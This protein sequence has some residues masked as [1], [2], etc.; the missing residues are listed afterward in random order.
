MP[1]LSYGAYVF[2]DLER[3][4]VEE[5]E[6]AYIIWQ[7]LAN[8]ES[9]FRLFNN[10]LSSMRRYELLRYLFEE[11]VNQFNVQRLTEPLKLNKFPIFIRS[12]DDHEAS[13][14]P[15][16]FNTKQYNDAV[17]TILK[18]GK[19]RDNKI[20]IEY[21]DTRD[22][23]GFFHRFS[24]IVAGFQ[25]IAIIPAHSRD[26]IVKEL[27]YDSR[28]TNANLSRYKNHIPELIRIFRAANINY[29]RADY[30][31]LDNKIQIFEINTNP[32]IGPVEYLAKVAQILDFHSEP[33]HVEIIQKYSPPWKERKSKSYWAGR[34]LH[35]ILRTIDK[36]EYE[37]S[38]LD[39]LK[40]IKK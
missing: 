21:I 31:V 17:Q 9:R 30:V 19:S 12:E 27:P 2:A 37:G 28:D 39:T 22:E 23:S 10:P 35:H 18:N 38:I 16:L 11:N 1:K 13:I 4:S 29:G 25:V 7:T 26:W 20:V 5:T 6:R 3:L 33:G 32:R 8:D 24:A 36:L 15:L 34:L 40:S 14:T